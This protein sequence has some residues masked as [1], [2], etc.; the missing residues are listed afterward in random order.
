MMMKMRKVNRLTDGRTTGNQKSSLGL[1]AQLILKLLHVA[2]YH[3]PWS[4]KRIYTTIE[5]GPGICNFFKS[6]V[7]SR[8]NYM[9]SSVLN[10]LSCYIISISQVFFINGI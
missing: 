4:K 7:F 9:L 10:V 2:I 6:S 5:A 1:S 3:P 8:E